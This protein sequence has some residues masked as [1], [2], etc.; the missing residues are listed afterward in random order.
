MQGPDEDPVAGGGAD[1]GKGGTGED[2][3]EGATPWR[4]EED[5]R[6]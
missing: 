2:A 1:A 4:G 6:R 3:G 5:S